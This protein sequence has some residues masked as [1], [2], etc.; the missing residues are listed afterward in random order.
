MIKNRAFTILELLV[1]LA[2]IGVFSAIAYPN[3]SSW[4]ADRNVKNA[5]FETVAFVK[6]RK[7]E[8]TSGKY[9]MTQILF[10]RQLQVFTMSP[11]KFIEI[12]KST[13]SPFSSHKQN[14]T[15][16]FGDTAGFTRQNQ[17]DKEDFGPYVQESNVHIYPSAWHNPTRTAVCITKDGSISYYRPNQ[18]GRIKDQSTGQMVDFFL[19]CSKSNST[20]RSCKYNSNLEYRYMITLDR[21]QNMKV[22]R[23]NKSKNKWNKVDG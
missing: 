21:F 4:I 22:F 5:A 2:V 1:V 9:G 11:N 18:N 17:Y 7:S 14:Y 16:G 3:V 8:V 20:E 15:C 19:F 10:N 12:Y 13:N 6:D 23:Y